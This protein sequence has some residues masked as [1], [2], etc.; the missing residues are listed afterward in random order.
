M[1][2]IDELDNFIY[3]IKQKFP[4]DAPPRTAKEY[5]EIWS[6]PETAWLSQ[7]YTGRGDTPEIDLTPDA[8]KALRWL[9]N[10]Q[11]RT[12]V[13]TE[14]RLLT[15][16]QLLKELTQKIETDPE[17]LLA[18]LYLKKNE[19]EEQIVN[20]KNGKMAARPD[21]T[22]IRERYFQ[23]DDT[24][25][26]LLSDFRQ[27]EENFRKLDREVREKIALSTKNKGAVIDDI[28][29]EQDA[30][31]DS[32]QGKSFR[33]F[34]EF[35][36]HNDRQSEFEHML[37]KL[38]NQ[39]EVKEM[40]EKGVLPYFRDFLLEAGNKVYVVNNL[41][42]NQLSKYLSDLGRAE[43]KRIIDLVSQIEK[44]AL[45]LRDG[46]FPKSF[47]AIDQLK[48]QLNLGM[49]RPLFSPPANNP[50]SQ[51]QIDSENES[52]ETSALQKLFANNYVDEEELR[53]FIEKLLVNKEQ[54]SLEEVLTVRP[55]KK[56]LT[57]LIVYLKIAE[58]R[59]HTHISSELRFKLEIY[60]RL[61]ERVVQ[62]EHTMPMQGQDQGQ[63]L[64]GGSMKI[65]KQIECPTVIFQRTSV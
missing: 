35:L 56:G 9:E 57:E 13:G 37:F 54:V 50:L 41:L 44:N 48:P 1:D 4:E 14:S 22:Q 8:E 62:S 32:D 5:I 10:L 51:P 58:T 33:A 21:S 2:L 16:F 47:F 39:P 28:F 38:F 12:F 27:V 24:A 63:D 34:W 60:E 19:I 43:N 52:I 25:N 7:R 6:S 18:D 23:L 65:K 49:N 36:I 20:I 17:Q 31:S 40:S 61:S 45:N 29:G 3:I 30:I 46:E 11:P 53:D 55:L 59:P 64:G 42:T 26:T 15:I